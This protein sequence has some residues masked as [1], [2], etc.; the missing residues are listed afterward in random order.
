MDLVVF[1]GMAGYVGL[2][3]F[4]WEL[5]RDYFDWLESLAVTLKVGWL[6]DVGWL[7]GLVWFCLLVGWL[8]GWLV[9]RLGN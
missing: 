5:F 7:V 2:A 4:Y 1:V 6:V 9:G 8:V 3:Y